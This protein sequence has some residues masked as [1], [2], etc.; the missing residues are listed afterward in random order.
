MS[1][2]FPQA[3]DGGIPPN[4]ATPL[5]P[6]HAYP[7]GTA[8]L[9]T[10]PLYYGNGCD[11]RLR[12]EVVNSMISELEAIVDRAGVAYDSTI[13]TNV[14]TA[15]RYLI[16]RGLPEFSL[17]TGGPNF[18]AATLSPPM[19]AYNGGLTLCVVPNVTNSGVVRINVNGKGDVP[20]MRND[21]AE[22]VTGDWPAGRPML[23]S[24]LNGWFYV[25]GFVK[26]QIPDI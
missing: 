12:P 25:I 4:V 26:S 15:I 2:I 7:P 24:Y 5:N 14:E 22:L 17:L 1:G 8:P 10:S 9:N 20:V 23:I 19:T 21:G 6:S 13:L 11:V 3:A 18:Y 16:Q